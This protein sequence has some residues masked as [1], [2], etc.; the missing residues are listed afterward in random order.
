MSS[1]RERAV[2]GNLFIVVD[3]G[4]KKAAQNG[5]LQN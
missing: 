4:M 5:R 1:G 3:T 2:M